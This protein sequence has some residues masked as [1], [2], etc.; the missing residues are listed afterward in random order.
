MG[1]DDREVESATDGGRGVKR[2]RRKEAKGGNEARREGRK[3]EVGTGTGGLMVRFSNFK[4]ICVSIK[5]LNF[6]LF[7]AYSCK[8]VFVPIILIFAQNQTLKKIIM[9][10]FFLL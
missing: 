7:C 5:L 9:F 1:G 3:S 2:K 6:T 10:N 4:Q 8:F